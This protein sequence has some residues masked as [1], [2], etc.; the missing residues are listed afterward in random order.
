MKIL[1]G[2]AITVFVL[3]AGPVAQERLA[4]EDR[5]Y[6]AAHLEM[7]REFVLDAARGL[8]KEQWA[9]KPGPLRWSIAECVDHLA[10]TE[11]YV[12]RIMRERVLTSKDPVYGVF[13][14]TIQGKTA[15]AVERPRRM[16]RADDAA[17][18]LGMTDRS[19]AIAR[20]VAERPP[21]EEIAPRASIDDPESALAHFL[22]TRAATI[23]YVK[24]T[25]ADL[26]GH[27]TYVGSLPGFPDMR[28]H[29]V[30]QWLLRM[31][32]HT[33][34]HLMQIHDVKRDVSYP[35]SRTP[36]QPIRN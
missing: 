17:V 30:Y 14:S 26:R 3:T 2:L 6:L 33:E 31:S 18:L 34:R 27:Y 32:A 28:F 12:L 23:A 20:S 21:V 36:N 15:P 5:N 1:S 8:T 4:A 19:P 25:D 7:T 16:T 11:E 22:A 35:R 9:F 13:P 10:R 29:D 24:T